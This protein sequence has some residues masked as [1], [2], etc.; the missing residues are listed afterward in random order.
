MDIPKKKR[1]TE[2]KVDF[3]K[4][5]ICQTDTTEPLVKN[6]SND[7]YKNILFYVLSRGKYGE[8]EFLE[9]S[10]CLE[11]VSEDDLKQNSA[12]FHAS[13]RKTTVSSEK[14]KRAQTRF[15]KHLL[16]TVSLFF[17]ALRD[18]RHLNLNHAFQQVLTPHLMHHNVNRVHSLPRTT[19]NCAFFVKLTMRNDLSTPYKVKTGKTALRFR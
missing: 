7:A 6:V 19:R 17:L 12:S 18:D 10:K 4:C 9:A 5:I 2:E 3:K 1:Q 11:G 8:S 16:L 14:L 13:R 15:Q